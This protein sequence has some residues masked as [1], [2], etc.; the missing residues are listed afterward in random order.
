MKSNT[1]SAIHFLKL[2]FALGAVFSV[3]ICW[4]FR[5]AIS[6]SLSTAH[7]PINKDQEQ[8]FEVMRNVAYYMGGLSIFLTL[9]AVILAFIYF[10]TTRKQDKKS[11]YKLVVW[12]LFGA[13]LI[14]SV[15][16]QE[17]LL[18]ELIIRNI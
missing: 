7:L 5:I 14:A 17:H 16:F 3:L 2:S 1:F 10:A 6:V 13:F 15:I 12:V 8:G 11:K 9:A 18:R 4:M